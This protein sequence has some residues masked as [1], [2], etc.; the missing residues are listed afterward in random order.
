MGNGGK[1]LA[2]KTQHEVDLLGGLN[3]V[4][5]EGPAK[6]LPRIE[7]DIDA[8]ET[9][10]TLAP[11]TNGEVAV[12]AWAALSA[13]TGFSWLRPLLLETIVTVLMP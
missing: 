6:G 5:A 1:G 9:I 4:V 10:L 2:W 3:G 12:K 7:T 11:E 8:C 13:Q